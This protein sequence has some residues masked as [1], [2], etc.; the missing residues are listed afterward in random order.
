M[1]ARSNRGLEKHRE[2]FVLIGVAVE[3]A[4]WHY[5]IISRTCLFII[6]S[7]KSL[8]TMLQRKNLTLPLEAVIGLFPL[9]DARCHVTS[10]P[11]NP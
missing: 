4:A 11:L 7:L 9:P 1:H 8:H 6:G 5:E 10:I 2:A 3:T